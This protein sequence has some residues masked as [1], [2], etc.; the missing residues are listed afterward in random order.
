M[1]LELRAPAARA[2]PL[3]MGEPFSV[4]GL[5]RYPSCLVSTQYGHRYTWHQPKSF[6]PAASWLTIT[7]E[8]LK[9]YIHIFFRFV[10]P[11]KQHCVLIVYMYM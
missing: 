7:A 10:M 6:S 4:E 3:D 2:L 11:N 9:I 8:L 5:F 1:V